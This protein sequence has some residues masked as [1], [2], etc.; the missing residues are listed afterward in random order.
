MWACAGLGVVLDGQ[1]RHVSAGEALKC[2][3]VEIYMRRNVAA[4]VERFSFDRKAAILRRDLHTCR[5]QV[6]DRFVAAAVAEL[7]LERLRADR[8]EF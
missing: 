8:F 2:V 4:A 1:D 7:E 5:V 6:L 3:V